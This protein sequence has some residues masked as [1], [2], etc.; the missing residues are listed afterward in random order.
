MRYAIGWF[1]CKLKPPK[2]NTSREEG[3]KMQEGS[4]KDG[5]ERRPPSSKRW[6]KEALQISAGNC[7]LE[8]DQAIPENHLTFDQKVTISAVGT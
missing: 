7:C 1:K 4:S 5:K 6:S 3:G 2:K 8:A